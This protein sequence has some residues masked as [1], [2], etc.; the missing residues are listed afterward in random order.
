MTKEEKIKEAYGSRYHKLKES[1]DSNGWINQN[2]TTRALFDSLQFNDKEN[3][4]R[5]LE[6]RGIENNNGWIKIESESDLP[7]DEIVEYDGYCIECDV[8]IRNI[9][10][11][12]I[13]TLYSKNQITHYQPIKRLLKP[14]Y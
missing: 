14:I 9:G 10:S 11:S 13:E 1:I 5:P 4:M 12:K 2:I 8:F 6:L 7:K 3:L